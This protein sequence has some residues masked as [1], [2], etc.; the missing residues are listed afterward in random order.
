MSS[1]GSGGSIRFRIHSRLSATATAFSCA[2]HLAMIGGH[3]NWAMGALLVGMVALCLPCVV[4]LWR[5]ASVGAARRVTAAALGMVALH[6]VI[7]CAGSP[8]RHAHS[9]AGNLADIS[10]PSAHLAMLGV[11]AVELVTAMTASS[12][13]GRLLS[14]ERLRVHGARSS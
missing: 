1:A 4:H 8:A 14:S 7:L 6:L 10:Q 12:L 3:G 5:S 2:L 11:M 9:R 13:A